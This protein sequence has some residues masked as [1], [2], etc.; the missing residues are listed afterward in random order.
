[1]TPSAYARCTS[2]GT[3]EDDSTIT[4]MRFKAPC[5]SIHSSTSKPDF[6]GSFRSSTTRD[7]ATL[8]PFDRASIAISPSRAITISVWSPL[9]SKAF[10]SRKRSSVSSSTIRIGP[11]DMSLLSAGSELDPE[12]AARAGR[13]LHAAASAHPLDAASHDRQPDAR[14]GVVLHPVQPL[15]GAEDALVVGFVDADPVVLD[16]EPHGALPLLGPNDHV[17]LDARR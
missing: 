13:R 15:E 17:R 6:R 10:C 8:A 14:P 16:P 9:F 11:S 12:P 5:A 7:G 3:V 1:M 4:R 2:D